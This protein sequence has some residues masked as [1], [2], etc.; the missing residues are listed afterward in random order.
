LP[1]KSNTCCNRGVCFASRER[2]LAQWARIGFFDLRK[3]VTWS[4]STVSLVSSEEL[5]DDTALAIS[6]VRHSKDGVSIKAADRIAALTALSKH[7]GLFADEGKPQDPFVV[8]NIT[9][10]LMVLEGMSEIERIRRVATLLRRAAKAEAA[11]AAAQ[12]PSKP[13]PSM[14]YLDETAPSPPLVGRSPNRVPR[15]VLGHAFLTRSPSK[16]GQ[17]DS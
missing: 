14:S 13:R 10:N 4:G 6:E 16:I 11:R 17:P 1:S 7:L 15:G 3:A 9:N 12:R 8:T 2:V 5:D